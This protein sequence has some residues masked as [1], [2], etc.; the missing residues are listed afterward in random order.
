MHCFIQQAKL[1]ACNAFT[2][3]CALAQRHRKHSPCSPSRQSTKS[4][5]WCQWPCMLLYP[6]SESL[7]LVRLFQYS[8]CTHTASGR[9]F[10]M[11]AFKA[12]NKIHLTMLAAVHICWFTWQGRAHRLNVFSILSGD[13]FTA[14]Q[15]SIGAHAERTM[16]T[17]Y[18]MLCGGHWLPP[19][20]GA[21]GSP[22]CWVKISLFSPGSSSSCR[23]SSKTTD[24][25]RQTRV[26]HGQ[27]G[28]QAQ[29]CQG[30]QYRCLQN[31]RYEAVREWGKR[32]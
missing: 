7:P 31:M 22:T 28:V 8:L 2:M 29:C 5:P 30:Q 9:A 20:I 23:E 11:F 4:T 17:R 6:A 21:S 13:P 10:S 16:A 12:V 1:F 24:I 26:V 15:S 32:A 18:H 3:L 25:L 27:V 14:S 19:S